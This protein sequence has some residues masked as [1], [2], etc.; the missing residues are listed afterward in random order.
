MSPIAKETFFHYFH[1]PH[2][3]DPSRTVFYERMPK[4]LGSSI[5]CQS[6]R[7]KL[8]FGWGMHIIEGPNKPLIAWLMTAIVVT[9]FVVSVVYDVSLKNTDSGFAIGQWML[10]VLATSLAA[11]YFHLADAV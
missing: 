6:D 8:Q 2:D 3:P 11:L 5:F 7:S 4:K 1:N 9:S 10:A